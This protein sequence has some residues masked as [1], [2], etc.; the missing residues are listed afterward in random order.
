M[1]TRVNVSIIDSEISAGHYAAS[2]FDIKSELRIQNGTL[3]IDEGNSRKL[4]YSGP[5]LGCCCS[6]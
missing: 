4:L 6:Y 2:Q 3:A 5:D 1:R